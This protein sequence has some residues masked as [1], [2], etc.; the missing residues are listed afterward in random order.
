MGTLV[1]LRKDLKD[2]VPALYSQRGKQ[3]P[4]VYKR[5]AA[6]K[7]EWACYLA[8][9]SERGS[10]LI[11]FGY[12]AGKHRAWSSISLS[13]LVATAKKAHLDIQIDRSFT[14]IEFSKLRS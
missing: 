2:G 10:D 7:T 12:F 9:V 13:H 6:R 11:L 14:P 1:E 4:V 8:E 5:L 3:D